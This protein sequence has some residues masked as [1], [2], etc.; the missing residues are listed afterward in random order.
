MNFNYN[1]QITQAIGTSQSVNSIE[2]ERLEKL[3]SNTFLK[4]L[5]S[6]C[7][8][9]GKISNPLYRKGYESDIPS[10]DFSIVT[11]ELLI[12]RD[13][14][15][16]IV[17]LENLYNE[18]YNSTWYN[19]YKFDYELKRYAIRL[20][21]KFH[22]KI[23]QNTYEEDI[24]LFILKHKDLLEGLLSYTEIEA[25]E[26]YCKRPEYIPSEALI[27]M[28]NEDYDIYV[29]ANDD[30]F[31]WELKTLFALYQKT[32]SFESRYSWINSNEAILIYYSLGF[33]DLALT[34][35]WVKLKD[36]LLYLDKWNKEINHYVGVD[37]NTNFDHIQEKHINK[38][39]TDFLQKIKQLGLVERVFFLYDFANTIGYE[40]WNG[41]C[42]YDTKKWG[43]N[44][45]LC[46]KKLLDLDLLYPSDEFDLLSETLSKEELLSFSSQ[47]N[48]PIKKSWTKRKMYDTI[49]DTEQGKSLLI[50][51][52][53]KRGVLKLNPIYKQDMDCTLQQI[54]YNKQILQLLCM[55]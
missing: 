40:L 25:I 10:M 15:T 38:S 36:R 23:P 54:E 41:T 4:K 55:I 52:V 51:E 34:D 2:L 20:L 6:E 29:R 16:L 9:F 7:K 47:I 28:A 8:E 27:K 12:K 32:P 53:R 44:E 37:Y 50:D 48:V 35:K 26:R 45:Q 33:Y 14:D 46:I 19:S 5:I 49:I 24:N 31:Y 17:F 13:Y 22:V 39:C 30:M 1:I 3:S 11:K 21:S 42:S 43:I 18:Y